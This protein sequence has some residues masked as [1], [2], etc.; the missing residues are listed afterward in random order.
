MIMKKKKTKILVALLSMMLIVGTFYGCSKSGE[1]GESAEDIISQLNFDPEAPPPTT[2]NVIY[3]SGSWYE[4]GYQ[5]GEQCEET[6]AR[7]ISLFL[8]SVANQFGSLD[9]AREHTD[10]YLDLIEKEMPELIDMW[11]GMADATGIDYET[12]CLA[13]LSYN[14]E[15]ATKA[16]ADQEKAEN[17]ECSTTMAWGDATKDGRLIAGIQADNGRT[18]SYYEPAVVVYPEK[19]NA[20]ITYGS[21]RVGIVSNGVMNE[22]GLVITACSGQENAKGDYGDGTPVVAEVFHLAWKCDTAEEAKDM[23]VEDTGPGTGENCIIA[24]PSGTAYVIEH[25]ARKDSVRK[26]GDFGEKD[27]I[28]SSNGYLT[29]DM[30]KSL[31]TGD[32]AWDDCM[33]RYWTEEQ[34]V[35]ENFGNVTL[36]TLNDGLGSNGYYIPEDWEYDNVWE[37]RVPYEYGWTEDVWDLENYTGFW[38]PENRE[39]GSKCTRRGLFDTKEMS[40]YFMSGCRDTLTSALPGATGNFCKITFAKDAAGVNTSARDYA[41]IMLF[42]GARDIDQSNAYGSEREE[43]LDTAKKAF[44]KGESYTDLARLATDKEEQLAYYGKAT[45]AFCRAQ[46]YAQLAQDDPKAVIRDGADYQIW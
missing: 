9:V 38:T 39:P 40:A 19:G 17:G 14:P 25:T 6:L 8:P 30:Q 11:E 13:A 33:P 36:D 37:T 12:I 43:S 1:S 2:K 16:D 35:L 23:Y 21:S 31:W 20:F 41:R 22:K 44:F 45:S 10:K 42:L 29:D 15:E 24:D 18:N 32:E 7:S 27:Y 26:S 46:C 34:V 28:V 4:I 5:Y 3:V